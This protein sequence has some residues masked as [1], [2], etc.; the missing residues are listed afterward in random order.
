MCWGGGGCRDKLM[1]SLCREN[2][3]FSEICYCIHSNG[4]NFLDTAG[5]NICQ[6]NYNDTIYT[7]IHTCIMEG[8]NV[9]STKLPSQ[10]TGCFPQEDFE[11]CRLPINA[12][13]IVPA[14]ATLKGNSNCDYFLLKT[15]WTPNE[16]WNS[17]VVFYANH[18]VSENIKF[19]CH[20]EHSWTKLL[21]P[22]FQCWRHQPQKETS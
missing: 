16:L 20:S 15:H 18:F 14:E 4:N 10:L 21:H 6:C 13:F 3:Y 2:L 12:A 22:S 17:A 8:I 5:K 19:G 7:H 11:G 9:K 1:F